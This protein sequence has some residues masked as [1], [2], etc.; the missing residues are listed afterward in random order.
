M[1]WNR[2][3]VFKSNMLHKK[4]AN[5]VGSK[6]VVGPFVEMFNSIPHVAIQKCA[7]F[8]NI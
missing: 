2:I 4:M 5:W 1:S 6:E 3:L 8:R 7:I